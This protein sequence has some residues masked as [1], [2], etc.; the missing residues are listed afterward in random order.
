MVLWP[1]IAAWAILGTLVLAVVVATDARSRGVSPLL[2]FVLTVLLSVFGALAYLVMRPAFRLDEEGPLVESSEEPV[3]IASAAHSVPTV[4]WESPREREPVATPPRER[5]P[6]TAPPREREP[7]S[8]P[9]ISIY[10]E[11]YGPE[12][13]AP[14][15]RGNNRVWLYVGAL[16]FMGLVVAAAIAAYIMTPNTASDPAR[17]PA[18]TATSTA[19]VWPTATEVTPLLAPTATAQPEEPAAAAPTSTAGSTAEVYTVQAGDTLFSIADRYGL[20]V[21]ELQQA[22]NIDDET[23]FEGQQLRIPE[24]SP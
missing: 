4:R 14:P 1:F 7:L 2:W 18:A 21:E 13:P 19:V 16:V 22:N 6:F 17:R 12:E 5:E 8:G 15:R 10:E 11:E 20:S 23:I 9:P 3:S 24:R